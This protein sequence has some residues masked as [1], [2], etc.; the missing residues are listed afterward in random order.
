MGLTVE[1]PRSLARAFP[2]WFE[3]YQ[4]AQVEPVLPAREQ[5]R[6]AHR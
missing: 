5:R 6:T 4:F 2:A 3:R 1:G